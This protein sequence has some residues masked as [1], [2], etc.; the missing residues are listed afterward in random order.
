[1]QGLAIRVARAIN[2]VLRRRGRGWDGR[3]HAHVL[4]TPREVRNALVYVLNNFR[5]H[6]RGATGLDPRS[7]VRWF[8]GWRR[9][10]PAPLTTAPIVGARTWLA[11]VGWRRRGLLDMSEAPRTIR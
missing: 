4:R 5:K 6:L 9:I 8:Q 7:S 11:R 3:Y 10:I 1:V 2:R